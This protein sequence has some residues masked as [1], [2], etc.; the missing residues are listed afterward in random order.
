[1]AKKNESGQIVMMVSIFVAICMVITLAFLQ[2]SKMQY[3]VA[4][5][6]RQTGSTY[7]L[8]EAS[9][10][11][12]NHSINTVIEHRMPMIV[13]TIKLRMIE[14]GVSID[15]ETLKIDTLEKILDEVNQYYF[16]S[17]GGS[18]QVN[19]FKPI[20]MHYN[21]SLE[22]G[23]MGHVTTVYPRIYTAACS[24]FI[25]KE[26][27]A[28]KGAVKNLITGK[29]LKEYATLREKS[30]KEKLT[31]NQ[32]KGLERLRKKAWENNQIIVEVIV[33]TK[34]SNGRVFNKERILAGVKLNFSKKL[35]YEVDE[36][37]NLS[38][39]NGGI[40]GDIEWLQSTQ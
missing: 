19:F 10:A 20:D 38:V 26:D 1:M 5:V 21:I 3:D 27:G 32:K 18:G 11:Q 40:Q 15:P 24:G 4:Q 31:D 34:N 37:L 30:L 36:K 35:T 13:D 7:S 16:E 12:F 9:A 23:E 8:A 2:K 25:S 14:G 28:L 6:I 22:Q 17:L 29:E 39:E 33:E